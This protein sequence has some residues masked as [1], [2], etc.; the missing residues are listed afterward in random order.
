MGTEPMFKVK[1][2]ISGEWVVLDSIGYLDGEIDNVVIRFPDHN[3]IR[4]NG[5][6]LKIYLYG[7]LIK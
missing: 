2:L 3:E 4:K 6:D 7:K 5:E 1:D